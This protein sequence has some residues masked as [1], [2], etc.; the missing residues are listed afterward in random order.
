MKTPLH[1]ALALAASLA[2]F[3]CASQ[4]L[5]PEGDPDA[6]AIAGHAVSRQLA[7]M[8]YQEQGVTVA[9]TTTWYD[10]HTQGLA[11][12]KTHGE[13]VYDESRPKEQAGSQASVSKK[14]PEANQLAE[15]DTK[16]G[17][18]NR[19]PFPYC[20]PEGL[21]AVSTLIG[22]Y[23]FHFASA[24]E[25]YA[26]DRRSLALLLDGDAPARSLHVVGFTDDIGTDEVNL[27]LS[28]ARAETVAE[29]IRAAWPDVHVTTEGRGGCPRLVPNTDSDNRAKNRRVE[30]FM[31][32]AD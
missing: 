8:P 11:A 13:I 21:S 29:K 15:A 32:E 9:G 24:S 16:S 31:L 26:D 18:A 27:P 19:A 23:S 20:A 1:A 14:E 3:G 7:L 25:L 4:Q 6:G 12:Y 10:G 30:I 2:A 17:H 28:K 22:R 5:S